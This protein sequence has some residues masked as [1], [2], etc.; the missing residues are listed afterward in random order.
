MGCYGIGI[1]RLAQA[2]V[3]QHHDE[4][5]ICW[6]LSIAPFQVIVVVA[7]VQDCSQLQLGESLYNTLRSTGI[8]A[9][10]DD[11]SE[12]AGVKFKDADLI[13][14][15]WRIVVGRKAAEGRVE[16]VERSTRANETLAKEDA[17]NR[18]LETIPEQLRI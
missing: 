17:L 9:L 2:A 3:E 11:R 12:R 13:G 18:L 14:I 15:P 6:P 8:D 10:L 5:G 1:S 4:V 7:N 16:L